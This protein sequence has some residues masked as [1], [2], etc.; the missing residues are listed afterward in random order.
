MPSAI[1]G[2]PYVNKEP[3][4]SCWHYTSDAILWP[5]GTQLRVRI[6]PNQKVHAE[7]ELII[8][9][10]FDGWKVGLNDYLSFR[11]VGSNEPADIR[12]NFDNA[13]PTWS[14]WGAHPSPWGAGGAT[15]N[16][17]FG[18]WKRSQTVSTHAWISKV[19][20]HLFGHVLGL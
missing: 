6:N 9:A 11:W 12:I 8:R 13:F 17:S 16:I 18:D 5:S 14:T 15:M 19:A 10:A 1:N 7:I 3:L 4:F 2:V 20:A